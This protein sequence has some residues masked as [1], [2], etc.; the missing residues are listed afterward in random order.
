MSFLVNPNKWTAETASHSLSGPAKL[1]RPA[2]AA[3]TP[4]PLRQWVRRRLPGTSE[5]AV[6]IGD[7]AGR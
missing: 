6:R 7:D 3:I 2:I 5:V 4:G 1:V